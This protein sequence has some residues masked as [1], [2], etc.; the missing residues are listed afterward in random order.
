M[1]LLY[2]L[3]IYGFVFEWPNHEFILFFN[4]LD[5]PLRIH[6]IPHFHEWPSFELFEYLFEFLCEYAIRSYVHTANTIVRKSYLFHELDDS[7][8]PVVYLMRSPSY[9]RVGR[10]PIL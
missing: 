5:I 10:E 3:G 4:L 9:Y 7:T 1:S 6:S 2:Y 8:E